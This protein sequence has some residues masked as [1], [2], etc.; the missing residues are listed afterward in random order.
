MIWMSFEI[1]AC[2]DEY[3]NTR[4]YYCTCGKYGLWRDDVGL[5]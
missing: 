4:L 2:F 5:V 3:I 1:D